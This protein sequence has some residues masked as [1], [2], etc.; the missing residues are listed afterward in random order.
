MKAVPGDTF[1]QQISILLWHRIKGVL[2]L[3]KPL[4][5]SGG[6]ISRPPQQY[7]GISSALIERETKM[8]EDSSAE[9]QSN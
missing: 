2:V 7:F 3:L 4:V 6:G 1:G 5:C 9:A 8:R